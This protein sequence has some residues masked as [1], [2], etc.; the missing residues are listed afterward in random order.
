MQH[1]Y[2][3]QI[4]RYLTQFMRAMSLFSYKDAKGK[5]VQV[6]VRYGDM[7]RQ[8][9]SIINK[10][11][12][13]ILQSTPFIACYIKDIQYDRSRLQDPTF[14]SKVNIRERAYDENNQEYL[15]EQGSNYTIERLMPSPFKITFSTDI[16]TSNFDQKVQIFEQMAVLFTPS[17]EIQTT[18]NFV[19]WTSLSVL[20]IA[21]NTFETKT[22]PQGVDSSISVS[23]MNFDAPIWISPP[24]KVKKLGIVTKIIAN[25]FAEPTG[26]LSNEVY[27]DTVG[28]GDLFLNTTQSARVVVTPENCELLVLNNSAKLLPIR[29]R[30]IQSQLENTSTENKLSWRSILDLYPGKFVAGLS[31]LRLLKP[32]NTEIV[33]TMT[34][35]PDNETEMILSYD[36]DTIPTNTIISDLSELYNRGTVDAVINPQRF[37][38]ESPVID[39][40]YLIL[41]DINPNYSE[42]NYS[43]PA[44][45]KNLDNT[46]F[47]ASANDIIQWDGVKWNVIFSSSTTNEIVYITNSYTGIQYKWENNQ[48]N[49]SFEG[50]YELDKWRIVL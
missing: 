14:V 12:E 26:T 16:W 33:A 17:L 45:W 30:N 21:S 44:A 46:D 47:V 1:F 50:V 18:D 7:T 49:K 4:K 8:V 32:N 11:S 37:V 38:P 48:W 34:L 9:A 6:P 35:N 13:N 36:A 2:S 39:T 25:I 23:T 3:G 24:A 20:E 43:G 27:A 42:N 41:E 10:N 31:Q 15:N 22:I 40:R 28:Y 19:D 29:K 5:L